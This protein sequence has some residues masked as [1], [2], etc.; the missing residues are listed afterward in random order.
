[1]QWLRGH[2]PSHQFQ[3]WPQLDKGLSPK[4]FDD[5]FKNI[6]P[7]ST[8]AFSGQR[9]G[10]RNGHVTCIRSCRHMGR[11][12]GRGGFWVKKLTRTKVLLMSLPLKDIVWGLGAWLLYEPRG[13]RDSKTEQS[14]KDGATVGTKPG[15]Q[16]ILWTMQIHA[17]TIP[18]HVRLSVKH[19]LLLIFIA[20]QW[21]R[22]PTLHS[23]G[24]RSTGLSHNLISVTR[25]SLHCNTC[26]CLLCAPKTM[27]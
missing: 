5:C 6:V 22:L 10:W 19:R 2:W 24:N 1:M 13:R 23:E 11:F 26:A 4:L 18:L 12:G 9:D 20:I 16:L 25:R 15:P 27:S 3:R 17:P 8:R 21:D 7:C 14:Y